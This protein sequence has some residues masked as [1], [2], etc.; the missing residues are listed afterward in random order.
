MKFM[1]QFFS[2]VLKP[3]RYA[4]HKINKNKLPEGINGHIDNSNR[5]YRSYIPDKYSDN[6][7]IY[8]N[9]FYPF[10]DS[11]DINN[12]TKENFNN[13][14]GD[15]SRFYFLNLVIDQL[16]YENIEGDVAEFGVYKGNSAFLLAK[17]ARKTNRIAYLFDSYE[18]FNKNDVTGLDS[19]INSLEFKDT[20][21]N[22][23]KNF[24]GSENVVFVKGYFPDSLNQINL[25]QTKFCLVHIDCDLEKSFTSSLNYFYPKLAQGGFLIM[26]D[27]SSLYWQGARNAIDTFFENK[28]EKLIPIPDKSGTAVIR[29]L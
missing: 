24:I 5:M 15:L 27:Y 16:I 2:N 10:F 13:N 25:N 3:L 6:I 4:V 8:K 29:K 19:K 20:S 17:L 14:S 28:P 1:K 18:G 22:Y 21:L 11:E 9:N 7:D 12:W 26:H 23:V